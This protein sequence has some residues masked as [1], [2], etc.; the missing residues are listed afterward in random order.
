MEIIT[1]NLVA[2]LKQTTNSKS[3]WAVRLD[4]TQRILQLNAVAATWIKQLTVENL[5]LTR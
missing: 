2:L 4:F 1:V 3:Y 5:V